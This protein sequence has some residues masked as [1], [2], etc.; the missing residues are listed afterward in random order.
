[1]V[2]MPA[3]HTSETEVFVISRSHRVAS[4]IYMKFSDEMVAAVL[5]DERK[6]LVQ[7]R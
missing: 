3:V 6:K 4:H 5:G 2:E 7:K 1:M